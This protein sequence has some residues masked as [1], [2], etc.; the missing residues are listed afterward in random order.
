M[1]VNTNWSG[2]VLFLVL[3]GALVFTPLVEASDNGNTRRVLLLFSY[4]K[5]VPG[6]E[7]LE[8]TIISTLEAGSADRFEFY[9]E[10]LDSS[11]F[12]DEEYI[13]RFYEL[14]H[15]KYSALDMDLLIPLQIQ[16]LD[17]LLQHGEGIFPE[18][19]IVFSAV[20]EKHLN[21]RTLRPNITGVT[22]GIDIVGT[23]ELALK[24]HPDTRRIAVISG[25]SAIGRELEKIARTVFRRYEEQLDVQYLAGLPMD[26]LLAWVE[27]PPEQTLL[28]YFAIYK[29]GVGESFF[30]ERALEALASVSNAPIYG[31][32]DALLGHSI[33]GGH[34]LS[35]EAIGTRTAEIGLRILQGEH[36]ADIPI[37]H[38][39]SNA[40][41]FDWRQLK[42]WGI[43]EK[44][45]PSDSLIRYK[46]PSLWDLYKWYMIAA[47]IL[48]LLQ[49]LLIVL[50]LIHQKRRRRAEEAFRKSQEDYRS[51]AGK[52]LSVQETE[53]RRL[54]REMHD[55]LTQRL[56]I[57][58]IE[59][60]TL[61]QQLPDV[62]EPVSARLRAMQAEMVKLS[63]DV[64][65][66]SRQLHPSILDDL[67][68]V[69]AIRSECLR[70]TRQEGIVVHYTPED[71]SSTIPGDVALCLYR[72]LQEGLRNIV[73]H[74]RAKEAFVSLTGTGG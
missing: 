54:A 39:V 30:P 32:H 19:P 57:Q 17:F 15:K 47:G 66:I 7:F 53:R 64:H 35:V 3:L 68:L 67:G 55:D 56:A 42:H 20:L 9:I 58:A 70:F 74:A 4:K 73:K 6:F 36:A 8:K 62:R 23:V 50:L 63:E 26:E 37:L 72:I 51:L 49:T 18:A 43:R 69:D 46:E 25:A 14:L 45:L 12:T 13:Q 11:R 41:M 59:I 10:H 1:H 34:L 48:F 65:A 22:Q 71:V 60:G 33:V 21:D 5:G 38:G 31:F 40:Y 2:E 28:F 52:L 16:A 61:E 29:D 44:D 27:N 24:L